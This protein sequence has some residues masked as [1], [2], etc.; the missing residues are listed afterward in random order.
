M[1]L[2]WNFLRAN[3]IAIPLCRLGVKEINVRLKIMSCLEFSVNYM[4]RCGVK[5]QL[6]NSYG[7]LRRRICCCKFCAPVDE[8][9]LVFI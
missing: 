3:A 4:V 1:E 5:G 2:V 9:K 6:V 7:A 8:L